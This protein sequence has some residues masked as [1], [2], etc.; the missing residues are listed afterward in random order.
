MSTRPTTVPVRVS[1]L[2]ILPACDIIN[3]YDNDGDVTVT[4]VDRTDPH[5]SVHS[6]LTDYSMEQVHNNWLTALVGNVPAL[7]LTP[8]SNKPTWG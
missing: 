4:Y 6:R 8:Q 3:V 2:F 7:T 5:N 1:T